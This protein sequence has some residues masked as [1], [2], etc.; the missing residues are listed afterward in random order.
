MVDADVIKLACSG[1]VILLTAA[2][3]LRMGSPRAAPSP[4]LA[5]AAADVHSVET[6]SH[7]A[8]GGGRPRILTGH[9]P[10]IPEQRKPAP[11]RALKL[12]GGI[13]ALAVGGA[14]GLIVAVRALIELF[15]QIGD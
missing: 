8:A 7:A 12:I 14:V 15:Q 2:I 4:R 9:P 13:A 10:A 3:A 11:S 1:A 6:A 5:E